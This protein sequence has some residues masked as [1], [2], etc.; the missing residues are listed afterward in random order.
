MSLA[1]YRHLWRAAR[2]AFQGD[3]RVLT[4]ARQQIRQGF[5]DQAALAPSDPSLG[6]AIEKAEGIAMF[7]RRNVV[8]GKLDESS[9]F[10]LRI[11]K[12]TE[13]GD[14]DSIKLAG[15]SKTAT[16]GCGCS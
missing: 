12:D 3:E 1:A 9:V 6:P 11:H 13:R 8:Q 7:L 14:N 5:R 4:A 16:G 15:G 10:K 2:I